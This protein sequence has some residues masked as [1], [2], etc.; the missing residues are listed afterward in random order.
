MINQLKGYDKKLIILPAVV[1]MEIFSFLSHKELLKI[2][3]LSRRVR[4]EAIAPN[5]WREISIY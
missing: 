5:L 1:Q 3:K 4:N 2:S